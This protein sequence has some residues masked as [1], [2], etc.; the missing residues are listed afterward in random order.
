MSYPDFPLP[1]EDDLSV[2]PSSKV[3]EGSASGEVVFVV[4][5][6]SEE[7]L[8]KVACGSSQAKSD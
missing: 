5:P 2:S 8:A 6:G 1:W 7:P 4:L 3:R